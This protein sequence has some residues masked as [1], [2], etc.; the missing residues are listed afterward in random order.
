VRYFPF[1]PDL[2]KP[3]D[4]F[5]TSTTHSVVGFAMTDDDGDDGRTK[6]ASCFFLLGNT[7]DTPFFGGP[8]GVGFHAFHLYKAGVPTAQGGAPTLDLERYHALS[9]RQGVTFAGFPD[10]ERPGLAG[11]GDWSA[12]ASVGPYFRLEP[13]QSIQVTVG[14]GVWPVDESEPR[15]LP[16]NH[17]VANPKRYEAMMRGTERAALLYRGQFQ[18]PPAGTPTPQRIGRETLIGPFPFNTEVA[19]CHYEDPFGNVVPRPHPAGTTFWYDFNCE[20]CDAV[21]GYLRWTWVVPATPPS[22]QLRIRPGVSE[23]RLEWDNRSEVIPDHSGAV[24]FPEKGKFSFWGY[25]IYRAAGYT[26]PVGTNGPTEDQWELI[27]NLRHFDRYEPLV[28]SVDTDGD[29]RKDATT[30]TAD[31]L[32][33]VAT[34]RRYPASDVPAL[35]DPATNDTVW[36]VGE[37]IYFDQDCRC[38]RPLTAYKVASYPIG[39]YSWVDRDVHDGF[40]YFYAVTALDS[41]GAAGADGSA[42]TLVL[43]EG[44]KVAV[45]ADAVIPHSATASAGDGG[46]IVV[47]NPYRGHAQWDLNASASDPSGRHV[48]FF[49]MP[50]GDWTLR[51]FTIAGDLVQTIRPDDIQTNGRPQ[52]ETPDDGQASWNLLSRNGQDVTS[53]IYLFSVEAPGF[54]TRGKFVIIR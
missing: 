37:R 40:T 26:R 8:K 25:R 16:T 20:Q 5:C 15:D 42:G 13:G 11:R 23:V 45:E 39:R 28:D 12:L 33:D 51:I 50:A 43:R 32:L 22:P 21:P 17:R 30:R 29:G 54:S 24:L 14:F 10:V 9:I 1:N 38:N 7:T 44:R 18:K 3:N 2:V 47:P 35:T 48:D 34:G 46:V 49:H 6:G 52:R 31:V 53:G 4:G 27:A 19:D 36:S 41:S